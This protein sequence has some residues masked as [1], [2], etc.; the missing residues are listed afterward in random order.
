MDSRLSET[1]IPI[2][3]D[4]CKPGLNPERGV[5]RAR[6]V[7]RKGVPIDRSRS[8]V[9]NA[10]GV[11][12][13]GS[14]PRRLPKGLLLHFLFPA[15]IR[16]EEPVDRENALRPR[17]IL[18]T[19][20]ELPSHPFSFSAFC[21]DVILSL[22][23][24]LAPMATNYEAHVAYT[25]FTYFVSYRLNVWVN[26]SI[27]ENKEV[28]RRDKRRRSVAEQLET[29]AKGVEVKEQKEDEKKEVAMEVEEKEDR[30]R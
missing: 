18:H 17:R 8:I 3:Q 28:G 26:P 16:R 4:P 30:E 24:H 14:L 9:E 15:D 22:L 7:K 20:A 5:S 23:H 19:P 12:R 10:L 27:A 6:E 13:A 1:G 21:L 2:A 29:L 25:S 11:N